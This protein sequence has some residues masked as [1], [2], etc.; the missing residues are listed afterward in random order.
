MIKQLKQEKHIMEEI[1]TL[2]NKVF[3]AL[4]EVSMCWSETPK[5]VFDSTNAERIGNKLMNE[6]KIQKPIIDAENIQEYIKQIKDLGIEIVKIEPTLKEAIE[7]LCNAL[8]E[9]TTE[10]SYYYS[11]QANIAM[12][13]YDSFTGSE[14][15]FI[16]E[17]NL[18]DICNKGAKRFLELLIKQ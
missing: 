4:G 2:R 10:G 18:L 8:R 1:K 7:V 16:G 13:I 3:E 17:K 15:E 9:D 6:F 11:W 14:V 5:G 12:S